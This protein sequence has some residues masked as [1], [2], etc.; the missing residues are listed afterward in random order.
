MLGDFVEEGKDGYQ[1]LEDLTAGKYDT[2]GNVKNEEFLN[3]K[4]MHYKKIK[5]DIERNTKKRVFGQL[6]MKFHK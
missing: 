2:A 4:Y 3:E 6:S 1:L 5:Q